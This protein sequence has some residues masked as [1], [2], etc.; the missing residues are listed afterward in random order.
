MMRGNHKLLLAPFVLAGCI[1][2]VYNESIGQFPPNEVSSSTM[3][4]P[5]PTTS[6]EV[7]SSPVATVT[8]P[9][10]ET[11]STTMPEPETTTGGTAEKQPPTIE[12]F[13]VNV[14]DP[15]ENHLSEA[16]PAELQLVASDDVVKVRLM[17]DGV[18]AGQEPQAER[19]P[20]RLGGALGQGQ[21]A[22]R[23]SSR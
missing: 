1:E 3:D 8:G 9:P 15:N 16:G 18:E 14:K 11:T 22:R 5:T 2:Q 6:E 21:R 10:D 19:F 17:L 7:S 13:K 4:P 12:L 23:A 20:P